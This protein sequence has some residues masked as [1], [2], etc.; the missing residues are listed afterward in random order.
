MASTGTWKGP[1]GYGGA[2]GYQE[3]ANGLH[4]LGHRYYDSTTGR[5]LTRD[6]IRDGKN[7]YS[8]CG[9]NPVGY[10]DNVGLYWESIIDLG[11]LALG[12]AD[13]IKDPSEE[14]FMW[15]MVD[16]AF[17]LA[18]VPDFAALRFLGKL[19][20][21]AEVAT[22]EAASAATSSAAKS[23][24]KIVEDAVESGVYRYANDDEVTIYVG[25]AISYKRRNWGHGRRFDNATQYPLFRTKDPELMKVAEQVGIETYGLRNLENIRN[26]IAKSN[27]LYKKVEEYGPLIKA[28]IEKNGK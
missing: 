25:R 24:L 11:F 3:D 7:W 22:V 15:L 20:P 2:F 16:A 12:L 13:F 23:E 6:P 19:T 26:G 4:L 9:N 28:I 1:S 27:P 10:H 17:L 5:F 8:Y 21:K 14:K 18:P